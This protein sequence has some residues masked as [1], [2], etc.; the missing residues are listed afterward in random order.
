MG[1]VM[2]GDPKEC[3]KHAA[4]CAELAVAARTPQLKATFLGLSKH[5]EKL[6][7]QLEN[8][9]AQLAES[10][11]LGSK[12]QESLNESE[13][14]VRNTIEKSKPPSVGPDTERPISSRRTQF[15]ATQNASRRSPG[16]SSSNI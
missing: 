3:R 5:W 16:M 4:R 15:A 9:F 12:V 8:A 6:A 11:A 13:K 14:I 10:E 1:D 2:P 7:I